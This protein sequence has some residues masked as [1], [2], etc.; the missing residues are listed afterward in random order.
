MGLN[1]EERCKQA[2]DTKEGD[3]WVHLKTGRKLTV[4]GRAG[5]FGVSVRH[6]SGRETVKQDHYL[7]GDYE[8]ETTAAP[9]EEEEPAPRLL[10]G[11]T[12]VR[13]VGR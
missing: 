3:V 11:D 13:Q 4:L 8:L 12:P 9:T 6:E 2:R 7:A 10:S 5:F 1:Y